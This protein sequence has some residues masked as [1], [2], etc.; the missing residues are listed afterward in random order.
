METIKSLEERLDRF[1]DIFIKDYPDST[2]ASIIE[3]ICN[4]CQQDETFFDRIE[5]EQYKEIN[6]KLI[7]EWM[8]VNE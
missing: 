5:L 2:K 1:V 6:T 3:T 7:K 8:G 4:I